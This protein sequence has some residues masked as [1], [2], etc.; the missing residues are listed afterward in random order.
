ML[1]LNFGSSFRDEMIATALVISVTVMGSFVILSRLTVSNSKP[2]NQI[3][4]SQTEQAE[5]PT[6]QPIS[7]QTNS[8]LPLQTSTPTPQPTMA[9]TA[10]PSASPTP[11]ITN[12]EIPYGSAQTFENEHYIVEFNEPKL[13]IKTSRLFRI[14]VVIANKNIDEGISNSLLGTVAKDGEIISAQAPLS[15]SETATIM[16]GQKLTFYASL[17]VPEN[18]TLNRITYV[19]ADDILSTE[20]NLDPTL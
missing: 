19:P 10:T 13:I 1:L 2:T 4:G 12:V 14:K 3:L 6:T 20:Y 11:Q 17:S 16:P 18:M 8:L 5:A 7:D 15:L 9:I